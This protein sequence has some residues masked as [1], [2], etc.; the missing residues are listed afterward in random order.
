MANASRFQRYCIVFEYGQVR[1]RPGLIPE[2][3]TVERRGFE[4]MLGIP[5]HCVRL[6]WERVREKE[7]GKDGERDRERDREG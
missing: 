1:P 3:R 7:R 5:H 6:Q 4:F 2:H